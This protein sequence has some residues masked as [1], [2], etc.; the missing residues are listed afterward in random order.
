MLFSEIIKTHFEEKCHTLLCI[1]K[2]FRIIVAQVH[3]SLTN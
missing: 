3:V 2:V 1:L